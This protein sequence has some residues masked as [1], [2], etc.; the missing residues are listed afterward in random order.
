VNLTA[1]QVVARILRA[2][3]FDVTY[4]LGKGGRDPQAASPADEDGRCDCSGAVC[5]AYGLD[6]HTADPFYEQETGGWINTAAMKRDARDPRGLFELVTGPA[7]PGDAYVFGPGNGRKYGHTGIIV[8]VDANCRPT[9]V[10]HCSGAHSSP[11]AIRVT[12]P[13][14]FVKYSAI[15][16]RYVALVAAAVATPKPV[17]P[18]A[19]NVVLVVKGKM[20]T[21]G[22]PLDAGVSYTEGL[23]LW[24]E[25]D[26]K[27]PRFA[28][29][30]MPVVQPRGNRTGL[31]RRLNPDAKYIAMRWA[32]ERADLNKKG[33]IQLVTP[34]DFLRSITVRVMNSHT[35]AIADATPVDW[36]PNVATGRVADLSPGLARALGLETDQ[37]VLVTIPVPTGGK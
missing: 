13:E 11:R 8:E 21:F 4:G 15:I 3:T 14:V 22:G 31:A 24:S 36:G 37:E 23:A 27:H 5:H 35:G 28:P 2:C 32:Y 16:I 1:E 25:D 17:T 19:S 20:S 9:K 34:R 10:A 18:P 6:R 29:M 33:R 30:L 12:G 26:V 7:R